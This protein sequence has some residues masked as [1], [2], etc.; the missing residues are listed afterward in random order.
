M[1]IP[2]IQDQQQYFRLN[3]S[4]RDFPTDMDS[5]KDQTTK[6]QE[7]ALKLQENALDLVE[8]KDQYCS[9]FQELY[10]NVNPKAPLM[11]MKQISLVQ[12]VLYPKFISV[13]SAAG[14]YWMR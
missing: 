9:Q 8:K 5:A 2:T 14:I 7:N 12:Y 6:L 4:V 3:D 1:T 10:R 13:L 11:L